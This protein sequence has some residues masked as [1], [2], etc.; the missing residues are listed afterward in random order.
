MLNS[1]L[2]HLNAFCSSMCNCLV[3]TG[4]LAPVLLLLL[5]P[6]AFFLKHS[7]GSN[8]RGQLLCNLRDVQLQT[9]SSSPASATRGLGLTK[10]APGAL[11][12]FLDA[13]LFVAERSQAC[14][15]MATF[16]LRVSQLTREL[17]VLKAEH[18]KRLVHIFLLA[19]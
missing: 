19:A 1:Q 12:L 8:R 10:E 2:E 6:F 11:K 13:F 5:T 18:Q 7:L 15:Q 9:S 16:L 14:Y 4:P 17:C 3:L